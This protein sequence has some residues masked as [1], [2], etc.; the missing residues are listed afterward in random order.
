[1][2]RTKIYN[3]FILLSGLL[4]LQI[5]SSKAQDMERVADKRMAA[6]HYSVV[7]TGAEM[8]SSA[9]LTYPVNHV[10]VQEYN[11]LLKLMPCLQVDR[12]IIHPSDFED[13]RVNDLPGSVVAVFNYKDT[14]VI[15]RITPLMTGRGSETW[16]G[17]VLYEVETHPVTDVVV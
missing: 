8:P 3:S 10:H 2:K 16:K 17:A 5:S 13:I 7:C 6:H 9:V 15:T 14:E 1:M 12:R 4:I 11:F